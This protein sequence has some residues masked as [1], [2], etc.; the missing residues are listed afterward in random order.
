[1]PPSPQIEKIIYDVFHVVPLETTE[2]GGTVFYESD[3]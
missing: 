1:M 2:N 3:L